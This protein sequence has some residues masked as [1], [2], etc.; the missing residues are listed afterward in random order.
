MTSYQFVVIRYVHNAAT[1]EFANV[2]LIMWL[3]EEGKVTWRITDHYSR[4]SDFFRDFKGGSY[5]EVVRLAQRRLSSIAGPSRVGENEQLFESAG[6]DLKSFLEQVVQ[7]DAS[8]LQLSRVMAGVTKDVS[9]RFDRLFA[10]FVEQATTGRARKDESAILNAIESKLRQAGL[11]RQLETKV[12]VSSPDYAYKFKLGWTNG[13]RQVL[14][15]ISLDY[16]APNDVVDKANTW[17]GRLLNLSKG[18]DFLM[19]GV[20]APPAD[21]ALNAAYEQALRL[22]REAPQVRQIVTEEQLDVVID[23]IESDL[24]AHS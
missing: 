22:L 14:E 16:K 23:S 9:L 13:T 17:S 8:A 21:A 5:R 24:A 3:P 10:E 11:L 18:E 2:G 15:P 12:Q 4:F 7:K 6:K 20:V 19:T 1:Q